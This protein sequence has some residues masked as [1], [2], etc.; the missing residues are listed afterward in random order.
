[1]KM[2]LP[3]MFLLNLQWRY[4][5]RNQNPYIEGHTTQ[6]PREKGHRQTIIQNTTQKT[7][8][9]AIQITEDVFMC[10]GALEFTPSFLWGSCCSIFCFMC[11]FLFVI[12]LLIYGFWL[13][14]NG[15]FKLFLKTNF[16]SL[17]YDKLLYLRFI[18][19]FGINENEICIIKL[20][21]IYRWCW[22]TVKR[23]K[24]L[25]SFLSSLL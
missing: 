19:E 6:R 16:L 22:F 2:L 1:M 13:P 7:K 8:D 5:R 3:N 4:Q 14:L 18:Y 21:A 17:T 20:Y 24:Q 10:P 11:R 25:F 15:I 12:F 23:R 9:R